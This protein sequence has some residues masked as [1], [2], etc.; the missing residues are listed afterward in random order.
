MDKPQNKFLSVH[1]QLYTVNENGEKTL[2]EQTSREHP[3]Q[4]VSGFGIAL[5]SFENRLMEVEKD[6]PF[7]FILSP[8][9][10]FGQ[11]EPEG[12]HTLK[13]ETFSINGHFDHENIYPGAVI[14]L[15]DED[16]RHFMAKVVNVDADGVTIDTNHPLAG[17]TLNFTGIVL[18]NREATLQEIQNMLNMLSGEGCGC[19]CSDCHHEHHEGDCN[20]QH[21]DGCGCGHC[22]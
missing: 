9:E 11:Y 22:H 16:D 13:R 1:Y 20:H 17:K 4:F 2:E 21:G 10:C 12:V 5:E 19:N 3:F 8:E 6:T 7:D 15:K 18:E 14:T